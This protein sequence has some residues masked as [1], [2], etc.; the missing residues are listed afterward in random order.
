M[1][2]RTFDAARVNA[3]IN[4]PSIHPYITTP[5]QG[6]LDITPILANDENV[7]LATEHGCFILVKLEPGVY[8]VHTNF[9]PSG[10]G[11][12]ALE[13]AAEGFRYMFTRTD[14]M[15]ILTKVPRA[16]KGADRFAF[17]VGFSFE[18]MSGQWEYPS[19]PTPINHYA[20]R[21]W[22]W[23]KKDDSLIKSGE[24]FHELLKDEKARFGLEETAHADDQ[25]H[26][27]YVG[28]CVEMIQA[29]NTGKAVFLYNR[30]ARFAGYAPIRVVAESPLI[31]DIQDALLLVSGENFEVL[32]CLQAQ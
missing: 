20:M 15:E 27:R 2:E 28:A 14:C 30:W 10:R 22:D 19:G 5:N 11:E 7:C 18:F 16:N 4:D 9:L 1:I 25:A 8:E 6:P 32:K 3:I 29:G 23:V 13:A 24:W 17:S 31:I 21:Y 12:H 26:D